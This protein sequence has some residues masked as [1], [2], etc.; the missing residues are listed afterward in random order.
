M[1]G[2]VDE[3]QAVEGVAILLWAVDASRPELLHTPF[4]FAAAA[5]AMEVPV[6]M[7]FTAASVR[8]LVPGVAEGLRAAYHAKDV[9]TAM[10][11]AVEQ[12]VRFMACSDAL[13]A[14]GLTLDALIPEC[15]G[16]GGAVQYMARAADRRW[17]TL[18]F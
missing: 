6:E 1:T 13:R 16:H 8:L 3:G 5:A 18:V 2:F 15:R 9:A 4:F 7:Y 10:H 12:G 11:E 14:Q 17:R